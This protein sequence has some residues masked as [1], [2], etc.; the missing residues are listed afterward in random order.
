M[1]QSEISGWDQRLRTSTLIRDSPDRGEEQDILRGESEG[2]SSTSR[3]D[4]SWYDGEAK[5]DFWSISGIFYRHHVEPRV[6]LYVLTEG[7]FPIP[8]KYIE[9]TRTADTTFDVMSEKHM[10]DYWNVDGD[11]GLPGMWTGFTRF[12]FL[13]EKPPDGKP[14]SGERLTR[15]QTTSRPHYLRPEIWNHM[16]DASKRK[17]ERKWAIDKP[18]L[19]NARRSRGV[20]F[21]DHEDEEFVDIMKNARWKLEIPMP[22]AMPC[23]TSCAEVAGKPAAPLENTRQKTLVLLKLTNLRES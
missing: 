15:K 7:S 10:D 6:K 11:R 9:V 18:K 8:L 16:S 17:E 4:S 5:D 22:A 2:S 14:W 13:S 1:E 12:T 19:D 23:T 20:Y 21:I 3:R